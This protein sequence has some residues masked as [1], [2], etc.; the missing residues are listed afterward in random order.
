MDPFPN[1]DPIPGQYTTALFPWNAK[2]A[3]HSTVSGGSSPRTRFSARHRWW[4]SLAGRPENGTISRG[5]RILE[6]AHDSNQYAEG[7]ESRQCRFT[8]KLLVCYLPTSHYDD[9]M[10]LSRCCTLHSI[11]GL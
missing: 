2:T 10:V 7:C 3:V 8:S 11:S 4:E 9:V 5:T 1:P 6:P